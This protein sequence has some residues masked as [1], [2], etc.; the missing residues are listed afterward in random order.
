MHVLDSFKL[1]GKIALVTGCRRGLGKAM[2]MALAEAGADIIGVSASL[3]A[4]SEVEQEVRNLGRQFTGYACD[5]SNRQAVYTFIERVK[6]DFPVIDI[7][8]NNAGIVARKPA[9]EQTD[10]DWD[11]VMEV[12]INAQFIL[13]REI[14]AQMVKRG[15]G[16]IIFTASMTSFQGGVHLTSY[17]TSKG[18]IAQLAK[19]LSNEWAESGVQVNA[20]A[21][22]YIRTDINQAVQDDPDR[23]GAILARIPTGRW[24]EGDDLK[25]AI[26]FLAS[27]ASN[28][29]SGSVLTVDGGWLGR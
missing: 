29:V 28:Y 18:G 25:G 12:N 9:L 26:V 15:A 22:G 8:V 14:G 1:D 21:P 17:A 5:F 10:A 6:A 2:A 7:L 16:K 19:A 4:G 27:A 20:L 24:G 11:R 13:S 23:Y 3:E